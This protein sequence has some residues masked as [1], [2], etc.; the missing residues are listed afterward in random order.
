MLC[1]DGKVYAFEENNRK[2]NAPKFNVKFGYKGGS[3]NIY[4]RVRDSFS[5]YIALTC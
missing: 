4:H 5:F 3:H 2:K 1:T